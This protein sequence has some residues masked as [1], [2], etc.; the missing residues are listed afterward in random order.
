M[1]NASARGFAV[2]RP[3]DSPITTQNF[4]PGNR[5]KNTNLSNATDAVLHKG[6]ERILVRGIVKQL[7]GQF[8]AEIYGFEPSH[9]LDFEGMKVGE[10]IVFRDEHVFSCGV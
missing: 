7:D 1:H 10:R 6:S 5:L 3:G 2:R 8:S 4:T 9:G